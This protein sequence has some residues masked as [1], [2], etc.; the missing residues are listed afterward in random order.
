MAEDKNEKT[1][2]TNRKAR[3]EYEILD[4]IEAGIALIGSEVKSLREGKANLG[5]A[6]GRVRNNEIWITDMHISVYDKT[7]IQPPDPLRERKLLLHRPEIKKLARKIEEKG[8]TL[9]PLRVYFKNKLVK[10]ELAVA[11]GKRKYDKKAAIAERDARRDID[12]EQKQ[13]KYKL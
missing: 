10:I 11:R 12:R 7:S 9:I 2:V 3:H 6:F 13:F 5:D 4:R 8:L 1:I